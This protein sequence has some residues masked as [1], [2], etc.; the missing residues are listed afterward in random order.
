MADYQRHP[1]LPTF[2]GKATNATFSATAKT[3]LTLPGTA[4][5]VRVVANQDAYIRIGATVSATSGTY[6][7]A[8]IPEY[9]AATGG[10]IVSVIQVST[11]GNVNV[12]PVRGD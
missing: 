9:I 4:A 11:A 5:G 12:I 6:L 10:E 3:V 1:L 2:I 8:L 7:V